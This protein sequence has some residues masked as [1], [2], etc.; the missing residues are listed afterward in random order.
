MASATP[1]TSVPNTTYF[2]YRVSQFMS[3]HGQFA[4]TSLLTRVLENFD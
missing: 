1:G 3:C 2:Q 4:I